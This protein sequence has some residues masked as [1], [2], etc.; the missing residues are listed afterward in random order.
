V[1]VTALAPQDPTSLAWAVAWTRH[2]L[3]DTTTPLQWDE[4]EVVA[5]LQAY[6]FTSDA[7]AYYRPHVAAASMIEA[8]ADRPQTEWLLS[9]KL[10]SRSAL[11]AAI[12]IRRAGRWVDDLIESAAGERPPSGR[13]LRPVF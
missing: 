1:D 7:V 11:D 8:D 4:A 12:G 2:Y 9:A 6:A 10:E 5:N 13:T 3:R